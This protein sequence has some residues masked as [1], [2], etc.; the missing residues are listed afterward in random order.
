MAT[1][2]T[3][4]DKKKDKVIQSN[5]GHAWY[6]TNYAPLNLIFWDKL[7]WNVY[8][9]ADDDHDHNNYDDDD[10]DDEESQWW[11]WLFCDESYPVIKFIKRWK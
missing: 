7:W 10:D 8:G 1:L 4:K 2:E 6:S 9:N 5:Y 3:N 11:W